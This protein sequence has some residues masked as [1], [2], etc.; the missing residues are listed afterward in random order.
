[1]SLSEISDCTTKLQWSKKYGTGKKKKKDT[2]INKSEKWNRDLRNK[3]ITYGQL[4]HNKG[5]KN[6]QK[7]KILFSVSVARKTEQLLIKEWNIVAEIWDTVI[8]QEKKQ[9]SFKLEG[10]K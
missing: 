1:M 5:G 7:W 6:I 10:E 8:K 9:T 3:C 2:Q 4:P